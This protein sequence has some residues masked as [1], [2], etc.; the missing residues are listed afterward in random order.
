VAREGILSFPNFATTR[1]RLRLGIGGRMPK[2]GALPYEWYDTPNIHLFT[3][4]DFE[5]LCRQDGIAILERVC[6]PA[7]AAGRLL[8]CA[9]LCNL[10]AERVIMRIA[11]AGQGLPAARCCRPPGTGGR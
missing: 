8:V 7:G 6:I 3:I 10:G 9:R 2:G 11:R 5:D 1:H 4:R